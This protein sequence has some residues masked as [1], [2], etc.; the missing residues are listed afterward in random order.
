MELLEVRGTTLVVRNLDA[1]NGTPVLDI[2][3]SMASLKRNRE[4]G[5]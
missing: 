5:K 3:V 4:Q 1:S 2:K